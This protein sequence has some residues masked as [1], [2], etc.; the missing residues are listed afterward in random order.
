MNQE[1]IDLL[2]KL[3]SFDT[4]INPD[5]D[6]YPSPSCSE[7][8]K[9][10]AQDFGLEI[11]NLK[12]AQLNGNE[13]YPV[14]LVERGPNPGPTVLFLGHIDV[15]PVTEG[16][17]T[18]WKS[19]PFKGE[20]KD[21]LL[22]G[23]GASDM[24]GGVAAFLLAFKHFAVNRGNLVIAL[25]G[26]EEVGGTA[27]LPVIINALEEENLMPNFV[28]NAEPSKI[29]I[30]VTR[31]RG[32]TWL[33]FST[34]YTSGKIK[35]EKKEIVFYSKQGDDSQ[36][37]HS[38]AFIL[39]ADSHAMFTAAKFCVDKHISKVESSSIKNNSVPQQVK[40]WYI[41]PSES[42]DEKEYSPS[43]SHL[44]TKL[45]SVGSLDWPVLPSKYGISVNPNL[46]DYSAGGKTVEVTFDIRAMLKDK[47]SHEILRKTLEQHLSSEEFE[48]TGEILSGIDPV[49]VDP[50]SYL[51]KLLRDVSE[52]SDFHIFDVGEKLGGASDTRFFTELGIPGVELGPIGKNDHGINESVELDSIEKLI[53]IF[54]VLF[55]Q[56]TEA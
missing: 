22:F 45:A 19:D 47:D 44:M 29:P 13:I 7:F 23:R 55:L 14:L 33:K 52:K 35:G 6:V 49:N 40:V 9:T 26:D 39:G 10:T 1:L 5:Q 42:G 48:L 54:Q 32:A 30:I 31:R 56:L 41:D 3:I 20:V 8:I 15:V 11:L 4:T 38:S 37:L 18:I 2:Q 25:S 28:I 16:E 34:S 27:S 24:K 17:K 43:L 21:N 46:I 51:P 53:K 50:E 36:T 12:S